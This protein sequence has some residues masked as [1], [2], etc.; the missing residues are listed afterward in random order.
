MGTKVPTK[1]MH[2]TQV[3]IPG[4]GVHEVPADVPASAIE[5]YKQTV[6]AIA[7]RA[8]AARHAAPVTPGPDEDDAP[9]SIATDVISK[10]LAGEE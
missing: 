8:N 5:D 10:I 7:A 4:V 3:E 1:N 9:L 6:F 2:T